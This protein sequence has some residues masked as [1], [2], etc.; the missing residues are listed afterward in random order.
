MERTRVQLANTSLY[1]KTAETEMW[2]SDDSD[3]PYTDGE[4]VPGAGL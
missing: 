4:D 2:A 3:V 1:R